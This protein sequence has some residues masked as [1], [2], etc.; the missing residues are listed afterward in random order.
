MPVTAAIIGAAPGALK[1]VGGIFQSIFGG[2]RASKAQ[3]ALE[4]LQTPTYGGSN[5]IGQYYNNA[6]QRYNTNP[7]T[8]PLYQMQ[9]QNA[10]RSEAAGLNALQDR[11]SALAGVGRLSAINNDASLK[12]G[13]MAEQMKNQELAQ[14]GKAAYLKGN[15]DRYGFQIN[16]LM[17]YQKQY[18]LLAQKAAAGNGT[19]NTGL[20]NT[21]G[22]LGDLS[23]IA[24][25]YFA[26]NK[27]GTNTGND[28]NTF[29]ILSSMASSNPL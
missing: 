16:K 21:F 22:G 3:N 20:N 26:N 28:D 13:G 6:L 27:N 11:R 19:L 14:L 9:Q 12:A 2:N 25:D 5:S 1:T 17:P 4:N 24:G 18:S 8:S 10:N 7:Y 23:S 29:N 15:D